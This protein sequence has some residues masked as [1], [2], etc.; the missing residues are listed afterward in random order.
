[1]TEP[2]MNY[3]T[4]SG[5]E[6]LARMIQQYWAAQGRAVR[7]RVETI[8]DYRKPDQYVY[9]VRSDLANGKPK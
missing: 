4:Q 6:H 5:A 2:A 1:M 8:K 3:S 7:T 9:V